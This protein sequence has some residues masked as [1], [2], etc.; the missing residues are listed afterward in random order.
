MFRFVIAAAIAAALAPCAGAQGIMGDVLAGKLKDPEVGVYAWYDLTDKREDKAYFLR[1]AIVGEEKVGRK[2]G[3][4]VETEVIPRVGYPAIY[5]M[6]LT[7][8]ASDPKHIHRVQVREGRQP[9]KELPLN[10][11]QPEE[12]EKP[13]RESLGKEEFVLADGKKIKVEH[14]VVKSPTGNTDMWISD[15]VRPMGIVKLTSPDG[16]MV[17]QRYGEGGPDGESAM[18]RPFPSP[19][20]DEPEVRVHIGEANGAEGGSEDE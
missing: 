5:K 11:D 10:Q 16:E 18:D 15:K 13:D 1:Q 9:M 17:L 12:Q 4:W 7:G 6:L 2:T 20:A 14:V 3:Y 8:P 19:D